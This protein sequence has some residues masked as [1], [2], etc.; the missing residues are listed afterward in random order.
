MSYSTSVTGVPY[1]EVKLF[2]EISDWNT[3]DVTDM[4]ELFYYKET[5]NDDIGNWDVS[6]VTDMSYMFDNASAFDQVLSN[7]TLNNVVSGS[8]FAR[9]SGFTQTNFKDTV[10]AFDNN[11]SQNAGSPKYINFS[12][13]L[14]PSTDNAYL[15]AFFSL[16]SKNF[17]IKDGDN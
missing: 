9:D 1:D 17:F 5:F 6:S 16:E 14:G 11:T 3:D 10:I 15:T 7:W 8:V 2:G 13:V 4:S 12:P